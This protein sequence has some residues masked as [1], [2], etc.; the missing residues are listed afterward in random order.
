M[1]NFWIQF[2]I[3]SVISAAQADLAQPNVISNRPVLKGAL[4]NLIA[5]AQG[6]ISALQS[7]Q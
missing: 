4:E 5:A 7:G 6:V 1:N 3:Y 2:A